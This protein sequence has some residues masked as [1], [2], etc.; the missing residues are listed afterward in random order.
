MGSQTGVPVLS[1]VR[2]LRDYDT[3]GI[4]LREDLSPDERKTRR[5]KFLTRRGAVQL[6]GISHSS[7]PASIVSS[8]VSSR[9]VSDSEQ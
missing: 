7:R 3:S 5:E 1:S 6:T 4:Y 9:P 2:K 8:P